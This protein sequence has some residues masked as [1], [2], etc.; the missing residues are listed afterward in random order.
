MKKRIIAF[1]CALTVVA[2][3]LCSCTKTPTTPE[4]ET[5]TNTGTGN[6]QTAEIILPYATSDSLNP[7][8]ATGNENIALA[9][10]YCQPLYTVKSD[11]SAEAVLADSIT[12]DGT[13]VS[14]TLKSA[15]FSDGTA[16][17]AKDVVYSFNK[18]KASVAFSQRLSNINSVNA[19]G[20]TVIFTLAAPDSLCQNILTFPIVKQGTAESSEAVPLGSGHFVF[21][22]GTTLTVNT[23]SEIVSKIS[24]ITLH[25][26]K[27]LEYITNAVEIGNIN[28]LFEDFSSGNY[29]RIVAQNRAV[30]L[31]NFVFL[32]INPTGA[33]SSSAVRTALYYAIDK[34]DI[35]QGAYQGYAKSAVTVFNPDFNMLASQELPSAKG[36]VTKSDSILSK[37]G[38][39][40]YTKNGIKTD[41][42]NVLSFSILVNSENSFR[43]S[44]A[45]KIARQ[46]GERGFSVTVDAV[47][48]D[49]YRQRVL[50]RN[51]EAYIGEV[52]LC[53][54]F[55]LSSLFDGRSGMAIDANGAFATAYNSFKNGQA[56]IKDVNDAF[57]NEMPFVPLCYR[58]GMAAYSKGLTP[59][60]TYAPFDIYGNMENW[61][62]SAE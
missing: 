13:K 26:I 27:K 47:S 37:M 58:M 56:D 52:K 32:G 51:Y 30:T 36:N 10:L 24:R 45:Q 50:S 38:Y 4:G 48:G 53:E 46:L 55:D 16:V 49:V 57:L 39:N 41:Q 1:C 18:A 43:V 35:S 31:N 12:T 60:F 44:A 40:Y 7:Y 6:T 34:E 19:S 62:K 8:F 61:E 42:T 28:Y 14:V 33:L 54:N 25:D 3:L 23:K 21:E 11:Y 2:I 5:N 17:T 22:S 29:K 9:S 20:S 59:D 15:V